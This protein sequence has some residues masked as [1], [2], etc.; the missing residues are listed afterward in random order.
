MSGKMG[1][2][3]LLKDRIGRFTTSCGKRSHESDY[4]ITISLLEFSPEAELL[5]LGCSDG[6]VTKKFAKRIGTARI[7][8]IEVE[9]YSFPYRLVKRSLEEALPFKDETFDVVT[10]SHII[11]H[12]SDTDSFVKEMHRVLK[13][14]GYAVVA[15]PNLAG[16]FVILQLLLN[17]QPKVATVSDEIREGAWTGGPLHRRLFTMEGLVWLLEHHGFTVEKKCYAGYAFLPPKVAR[18][19][20][21]IGGGYSGSIMVKVRK[22]R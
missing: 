16:W 21:S 10:A 9:D 6:R 11:E 8:G 1:N 17:R 3:V 2:G 19:L 18:F 13:L 15:T 20:S 4:Q 22:G 12:L 14:G 5:D 7:T